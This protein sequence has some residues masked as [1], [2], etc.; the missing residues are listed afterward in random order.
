MVIPADP[1]LLVFK[2]AFFWSHERIEKKVMLDLSFDRKRGILQGIN[3]LM[4]K[5][6]P[7]VRLSLR[8]AIFGLAF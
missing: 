2:A 3:S 4:E 1:Q 7:V 5:Q 6:K 8:R